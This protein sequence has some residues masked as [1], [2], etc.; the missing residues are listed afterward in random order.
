[1]TTK[2]QTEPLDIIIPKA[3]ATDLRRGVRRVL[4]HVTAPQTRPD[5][6]VVL[7]RGGEL[8]FAAVEGCAQARGIALPPRVNIYLGKKLA[9]R[10]PLER[11]PTLYE[12][13]FSSD[14]Q[15]TEYVAYCDYAAWLMTQPEAQ[16]I[17]VQLQAHP[18][19]VSEARPPRVL[20][21]DDTA[22]TGVTLHVAGR[23]L[24]EQAYGTTAQI[25]TLVLCEK[26]VE[27]IEG[28]TMETGRM[29]A[30]EWAPEGK[31]EIPGILFRN[32]PVWDDLFDRTTE[33]G[34]SDR[35]YVAASRFVKA[36][37]TGYD[38]GYDEEDRLILVPSTSAAK[39]TDLADAYAE[40]FELPTFLSTFCQTLALQPE[41]LAEIHPTTVAK[42]RA[43]GA[44]TRL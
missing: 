20:V 25:T 38:Y 10:A 31:L 44:K 22:Y 41:Q 18:S 14:P 5:V 27:W 8:A 43:L 2:T 30:G 1:M 32:W 19:E 40:E 21:V 36:V 28:G 17:I 37:L 3:L 4:A 12:G 23:I 34:E 13:F 16:S 35:F 26:Q 33:S 6:I 11:F 42:L 9:E 24:A 29:V 7:Q 39:I 15:S